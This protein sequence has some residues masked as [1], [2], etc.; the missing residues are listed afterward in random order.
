M[1]AVAAAPAEH[2]SVEDRARAG[3][4]ARK[5]VPR[6]EH[7][8]WAPAPDRRDPIALLERQARTRVPELVPIRH[9]RMLAG[10]FA[11]L[12]GSAVVMAADLA[13]TPTSGLRV[14]LC[15]DAHLSNFGL[16]ASPD[17]RMVFDLN[18]FDETLPGPWEW[19]VKRLA[20]SVAVAGRAFGHAADQRAAAVT[21]TAV[22]YRTGM[23][24][25]ARQPNLDVFYARIEVDALLRRLAGELRPGMRGRLDEV[26]AHARSSDSAKAMRK[27]TTTVD[28]EARIV[29][30]PPLIEPLDEVFPDAAAQALR[31]AVQGAL[32]SYRRTLLPDRRVALEGFRLVDVGRKVVG[33]GSVGTRAWIALLLGRDA[34]DPLFL[35]FKEAD[36]SVLESHLG[37]AR[38]RHHGSRVVEGQRLMQAATDPFLGT[39][40]VDLPEEG[41]RRDFYVRQLKDWKG[42]FDPDEARARGLALYGRICGWT[43][44]RAHAR[45]GDRIAIAAY[46]GSGTAF[47]A[48]MV[49]FAEAYADQVERDHRA[50]ETAVRTGRIEARTGI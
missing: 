46:L 33:V 45:S 34:R 30:R 50:L 26:I 48:A 44:A 5:A 29:S 3:K 20:A 14:Q 28:G 27:L 18:D 10:P 24:H 39:T 16:F 23:R 12:R 13:Q 15:G 36:A 1:T 25:F 32:R 35:Q 31:D 47:D 9:G 42:S 17:R 2:L 4:A 21:E 49:A 43:L 6:S 19:D 8:D 38:H 37:A 7:G 22:G 40:A 11:F 41:L